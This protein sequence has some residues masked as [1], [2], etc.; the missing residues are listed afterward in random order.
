MTT[1]VTAADLTETMSP[2]QT[3]GPLYG[4]CLLFPG[5]ENT[6]DPSD[7]DAIRISGGV[8]DGNGDPVEYPE[9]LLEVWEGE[10]YARTRTDEA[11]QWH[12]VVH[13]PP[14]RQLADGRV[15]VPH[16]NVT[17]FARGLLKQAQTLVYFP[18]EVEANAADPI[19]ELVGADR[20]ARMVASGD[21][22]DLRYDV[23]LQGPSESVFF[24]F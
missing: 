16:L 12:V 9:C 10:Q 22:S 5:S 2:S 6:V 4:F 21:G 20:S 8:Y 17:L 24:D 1:T 3:I 19:M 18:D 23:H 15:Q 13:K 11:G 14:R 7:A